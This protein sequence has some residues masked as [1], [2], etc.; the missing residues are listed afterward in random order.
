MWT[1]QIKFSVC[2]EKIAFQNKEIA[3]LVKSLMETIS[4]LFSN[5]EKVATLEN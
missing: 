3:E 2:L 1:G 4:D 5:E